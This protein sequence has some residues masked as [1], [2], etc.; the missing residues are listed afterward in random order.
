MRIIGGQQTEER[1][2]MAGVGCFKKKRFSFTFQSVLCLLTSVFCLLASD[3]CLL[4]SVPAEKVYID[5][6]SPQ[7]RRLPIAIQ[8]FTGGKE[9]SD[10]IRDDLS[11]TGLFECLAEAAQ[12]E[13]PEQP[14]NAGNWK[15]LG[16]ALVVK[17]RVSQ[18]KEMKVVVSVYDVAEGREV[19]K[20]EYSS[21]SDLM[22][23]LAHAAANEIYRILTGQKGIFRSKIV[24][25][26]DKTGKKE[27]FQADWDGK[28]AHG[29]GSKGEVLL[30]PRWSRD[31]GRIIYSVARN[32]QWEICL[33]DMGAMKEKNL[34]RL[35]GL[36][37]AGN[38]FPDGKEFV[39]AAS[40]DGGSDIYAGNIQRM[41]GRKL[42]SSPWIDVSPSVS[43]DGKSLLFVSNRS[44]NP[45]LYLSDTEGNGVRRLT[46][47]GSYN[48][49]P[50]WSP[51]GDLIAFSG[52]SG[53]NHQIFTIRPDGTGLTKLTERGSNE[54]PSFSPDGRYIAFTSD[55]DGAKGIYIMPVNGEGQ[56]RI[57]PPGVKASGPAWSPQY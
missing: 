56:K 15:G 6:T 43:P 54:D 51:K 46:F 1:R 20:K 44:G 29:I 10:L 17:G 14:F 42:I 3:F 26:A 13:R 41:T 28:R 8:P 18:G 21:S 9:V 4:S 48:T 32:R 24:F 53:G 45:Q 2:Q 27:I 38:F 34:V 52:M 35:S 39:F 57:T 36:N 33:F 7:I 49:S 22:R 47:N 30:A 11:F 5:I 16:A 23:P 55:R 19:L 31:G 12:I 25:V 40:K 50:S 37:M